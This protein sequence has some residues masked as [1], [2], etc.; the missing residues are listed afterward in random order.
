MMDS[1]GT[2]YICDT[3]SQ[4]IRVQVECMTTVL[5]L[6]Y[7]PVCG[8]PTLRVVKSVMDSSLTG[9]PLSTYATPLKALMYQMWKAHLADTAR[10]LPLYHRFVDYAAALVLSKGEDI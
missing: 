9:V 1:I 7:C 4:L 10:T 5:P 3:C 6:T 8:T 2:L